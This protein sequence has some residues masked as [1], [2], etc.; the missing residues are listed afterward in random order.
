[1]T[2]FSIAADT[3]SPGGAVVALIVGLMALATAVTWR[4]W[5]GL[6]VRR[7]ISSGLGHDDPV[8]RELAVIQ[9]AEIGL[10]STASVLL[11]A[12]RAETDPAVLAAVV[13]TV[14]ARQWEPASTGGIVE[15]RLWARAYAQKHPELRRGNATAPML[16]G[17]AGAVPP[18]SLDPSRADEFRT[19]RDQVPDLAG[20]AEAA[21]DQGAPPDSDRMSPVRVLVTGAGGPAGVSVIRALQARGHHVVALDADPSAAGLHLA[22]QQHVVPRADDPHYLAALLRVATVTDAQAMICTVAEEYRAL[23]SAQ[24]YLREAGLRTLMPEAPAVELCLDKWAFFEHLRDDAFPMPATGLGSA[25]GIPGPWI[26]KPRFGR[27]SRDVV[28]CTTRAQLASALRQV[29]DPIVQT[30]LAGREFTCDALVDRSGAVVAA[31]PRWRTET[32]GGISTKG[33]T[34]ED[35]A[36]TDLVTMALKGVGLIG[37]ANVQGFVSEDGQVTVHEINPRFSGGLPLTLAAGC[38]L[39]EEHLRDIMGLAVRPERL[40]ARPG[41]SMTRFFCEVFAG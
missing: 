33:T 12:V 22:N 11:R 30:Q 17:V 34:F 5:R 19:R 8:V 25:E 20:A 14:A 37:P 24:E 13:R 3:A 23:S 40:V 41:V 6:R 26:V 10:A 21:S 29:P 9:A 28:A 18:P 31:A 27:G 36:V 15:L 7:G 4:A 38:D 16:A 1:V 35:A 32:R 39:V 2:D